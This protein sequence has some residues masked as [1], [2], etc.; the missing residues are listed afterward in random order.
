V[1]TRKKRYP[2]VIWIVRMVVTAW[3]IGMWTAWQW[4]GNNTANVKRAFT[5]SIVK[6]HRELV[7]MRVN[8]AFMTPNAFNPLSMAKPCTIVIAA[9]PLL[10]LPAMLVA[11]VNIKRPHIATKEMEN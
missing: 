1:N 6:F 5:G 10:K 7:A 9:M 11:T 8:C 4:T 2:I 3:I